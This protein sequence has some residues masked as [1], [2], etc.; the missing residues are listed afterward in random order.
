MEKDSSEAQAALNTEISPKVTEPIQW[1][2][3]EKTGPYPD[4]VPTMNIYPWAEV[5]AL[6]ARVG[7]LEDHMRRQFGAHHFP[8]DEPAPAPTTASIA[9]RQGKIGTRPV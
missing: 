6:S 5:A 4:A 8:D 2:P 9:M 3:D 7:L 1:P